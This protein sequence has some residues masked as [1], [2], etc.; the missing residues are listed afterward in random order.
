MKLRRP[1]T[2]EDLK[3]KGVPFAC[4]NCGSKPTLYEVILGDGFCQICGDEVIAYTVDTARMIKDLEAKVSK[5]LE[6]A[7]EH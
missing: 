7:E 6:L 3:D 1:I 4:T 5:Y 2:T